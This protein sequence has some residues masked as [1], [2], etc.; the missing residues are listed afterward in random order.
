MGH[1][2]IAES[3]QGEPH[4][5]EADKDSQVLWRQTGVLPEKLIPY[6]RQGRMYLTPPAQILIGAL[7]LRMNSMH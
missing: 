4:I 7:T 6:V 2:F 3:W 1:F 5:Y